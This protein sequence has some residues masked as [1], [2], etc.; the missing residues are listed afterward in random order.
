[1]PI[2]VSVSNRTSWR[3]RTA[4]AAQGGLAAPSTPA[5]IILNPTP[6]PNR[7]A[8]MLRTKSMAHIQFVFFLGKGAYK[9]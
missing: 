1:M 6:D 5:I 8:G 9:K 7:C 2:C 4:H 3:G